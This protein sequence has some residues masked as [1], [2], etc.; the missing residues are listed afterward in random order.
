MVNERVRTRCRVD[1][2]VACVQIV[3]LISDVFNRVGEAAEVLLKYGRFMA[4]LVTS[5]R[6][7]L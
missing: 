4:R 2:F 5:K 6:V 3:E 1:A 7:L